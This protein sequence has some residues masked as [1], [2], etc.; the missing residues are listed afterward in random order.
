LNHDAR[1]YP[2]YA[3]AQEWHRTGRRTT[4]PTSYFSATRPVQ[5]GTPCHVVSGAFLRTKPG[6]GLMCLSTSS[7]EARL[8]F[9]FAYLLV[10]E[11]NVGVAIKPH[12][13]I[14][15]PSLP[16]QRVDGSGSFLLIA[17]VSLAPTRYAQRL[18]RGHR[19]TTQETPAPTHRFGPPAP[20]HSTYTTGPHDRGNPRHPVEN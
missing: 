8:P 15:V 13:L 1:V 12:P 4:R 5:S 19:R 16:Q 6:P 18:F 7:E 17:C 20:G 9:T 3:H 11:C 14:P 10:L 2:Q